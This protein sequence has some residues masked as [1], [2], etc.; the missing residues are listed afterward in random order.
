MNNEL[1]GSLLIVLSMFFYG[2]VGVF[3]R[4]AGINVFSLNFYRSLFTTIFFFLLFLFMKRDVSALKMN[5]RGGKIFHSLW[6][7]HSFGGLNAY[8]RLPEY[9]FRQCYIFA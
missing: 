4:F 8:W 1:K 3:S 5:A 2:F 7:Y 6:I 9:D